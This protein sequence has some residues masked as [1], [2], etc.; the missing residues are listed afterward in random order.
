[1]KEGRSEKLNTKIIESKE[2]ETILYIHGETI[3]MT[4]NLIRKHGD[5]KE[6]A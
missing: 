3:W 1:V 6:L 4:V 2:R 5:Q